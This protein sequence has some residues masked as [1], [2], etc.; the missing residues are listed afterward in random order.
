MFFLLLL[1]LE[2]SRC[3]S[4]DEPYVELSSDSPAVLDA[5]L[6]VTATLKNTGYTDGP[7]IFSFSEFH[8]ILIRT[9]KGFIF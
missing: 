4:D 5:P 8:V 6:T 9:L 2:R 7:F 3:W 1:H